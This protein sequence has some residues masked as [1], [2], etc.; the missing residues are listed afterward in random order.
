[1]APTTQSKVVLGAGGKKRAISIST[2]KGPLISE[3]PKKKTNS[4]VVGKK[5][6]SGESTKR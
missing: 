3:H 2:R 6:G 5:E 1:M 4:V